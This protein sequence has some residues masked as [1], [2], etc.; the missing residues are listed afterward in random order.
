MFM[1]PEWQKGQLAAPA[2]G[3]V[4]WATHAD[5]AAAAA[6]ILAGSTVFEGPTPP[7]TDN[8]ALD[9]T[10]LAAIATDLLGRPVVRQVVSDEAF[11]AK[12]KERGLPDGAVRIASGYYEACRRGEFDKVNLTLEQLIGRQPRTMRDVLT[13]VIQTAG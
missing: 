1:G 4:A 6:V 11:K 12:A 10:D 13:A 2:D 3:K 7:L 5:L 8:E 9:M